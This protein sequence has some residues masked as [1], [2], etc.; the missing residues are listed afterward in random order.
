MIQ[1]FT[2]ESQWVIY[3]NESY[4]YFLFMLSRCGY[5]SGRTER[6]GFMVFHSCYRLEAE[7]G[8]C[9]RSSRKGEGEV[10]QRPESVY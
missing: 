10:E 6:E 4:F 1:F 9:G 7:V 8:A 2:W 3:K 5:S